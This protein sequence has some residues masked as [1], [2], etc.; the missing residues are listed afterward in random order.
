MGTPYATRRYSI[1][2]NY[3]ANSAEC[4][5]GNFSIKS[6]L[7]IEFDEMSLISLKMR[8]NSIKVGYPNLIDDSQLRIRTGLPQVFHMHPANL[9]CRLGAREIWTAKITA[10]SQFN[11]PT[12]GFPLPAPVFRRSF[13]R[14]S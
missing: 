10:Y 11:E 13:K 4:A 1:L 9:G 6:D 12:F 7:P 5:C 14:C 8:H 2:L 3:K